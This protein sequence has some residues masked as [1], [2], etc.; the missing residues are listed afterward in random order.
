VVAGA[1]AL[2]VTSMPAIAVT[3]ISVG[4]AWAADGIC[5]LITGKSV[6][7]LV[8]DAV[9]DAGERIVE[10]V[11]RG[12]EKVVDGA[13]KVGKQIVDGAKNIGKSIVDGA[14]AAWNSIVDSGSRLFSW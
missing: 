14:S 5:E 9:V 1:A 13:K 12:V 8:S 11:S 7:E 6:T 3:A 10:G 4:V 2:G